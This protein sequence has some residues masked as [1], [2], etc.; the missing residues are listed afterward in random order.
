MLSAS[1]VAVYPVSAEGVMEEHILEADSAAPGSREGAG[2]SGGSTDAVMAP[3]IQGAAGR[4]NTMAA[5]EQLA[6]DT[7]GK[8]YFNT[9]DLNG[10]AQHAISDGANYYTVAYSPTNAKMDGKFRHI[11]LHIKSGHYKLSYRRGYNA[12]QSPA[13]DA[14]PAAEAE[15][16]TDML[17]SLMQYGLPNTSGLLFGV[18]VAPADP[19]PEPTATHA[20]QNRDLKGAFTRYNVD[21]F[22]RWTDVD[23]AHSPHGTHTGKIQIALTAYDRAGNRVNWEGG[24]QAM[25]IRSETFEA[26]QKSGVPAHMEVDLPNADVTLVTGVYDCGSGK[27]GTLQIPLRPPSASSASSPPTP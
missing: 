19:Q 15:P 17:R 13:V 16:D 23:F 6:A 1:K 8:A 21:F 27:A 2:H 4:A 22:I 7:G 10:A 26:I 20:G 11:D 24:M 18:R 25:D 14:K 9:N 5:M 3:Y 12:D